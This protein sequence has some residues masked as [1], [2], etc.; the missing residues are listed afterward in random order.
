[1]ILDV[2]GACLGPSD[3]YSSIEN[4]SSRHIIRLRLLSM[5]TAKSS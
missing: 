3:L 5:I 1:M 2:F 4:K